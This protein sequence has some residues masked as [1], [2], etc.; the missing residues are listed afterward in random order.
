MFAAS[1]LSENL[2]PL[3]ERMRP[4]ILA[5]FI[6]QD[7]I[8]SNDGLLVNAI[9]INNPFSIIF[10]GPPSALRSSPGRCRGS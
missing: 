10:W 5:D 7:Q 4:Q 2:P 6:G 1:V 3:A 8:L 9:R